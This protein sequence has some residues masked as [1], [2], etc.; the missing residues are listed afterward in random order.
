ML[1]RTQKYLM[2]TI[3]SLFA[4]GCGDPVRTTVQQVRLRLVDSTSRQPIVGAQLLLKVDFDAAYP[5]SETELTRKEWDHCKSFWDQ[6]LWFR[7]ATDEQG[8][9]NI[10]VEETALDRS[11]GATPPAW[12]DRVTGKPFIVRV[13]TAQMPT[14]V[15]KLGESPEER[16]SLLMEPGESA[17]GRTVVVTVLEIHG[18]WYVETK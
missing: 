5:L 6:Q 17:D 10:V 2:W 1:R 18:P 9:A 15:T 3:W 16:L 11:R 13:K 12:R 7:G 4:V 8:N 14:V